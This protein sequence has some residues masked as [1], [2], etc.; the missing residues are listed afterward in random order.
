LT[1]DVKIIFPHDKQTRTM[2]SCL[3]LIASIN[4]GKFLLSS[5]GARNLSPRN[6]EDFSAFTAAWAPPKWFY[7]EGNRFYRERPNE[8][9]TDAAKVV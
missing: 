4:N 7:S 9:G 8:R 5:L 1:K 2:R 6:A 3:F